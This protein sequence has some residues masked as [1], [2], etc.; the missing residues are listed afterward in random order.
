[1]KMKGNSKS[2][3]GHRADMIAKSIEIHVLLLGNVLR[4]VLG[5]NGIERA[6]LT[7][8]CWKSAIGVETPTDHDY[9][10]SIFVR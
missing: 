4:A 1:M 8:R 7:S 5:N 3:L 10:H 2:R 6:S 9:D